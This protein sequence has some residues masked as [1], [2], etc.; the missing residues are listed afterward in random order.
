MRRYVFYMEVNLKILM[1]GLV[2]FLTGC[3]SDSEVETTGKSLI[4]STVDINGDDYPV[5][6]VTWSYQSKPDVWFNLECDK[7]VCDTWVL[8]EDTE[9]TVIISGYHSVPFEND[10]YCSETFS[11]RNS[12][13]ID[14]SQELTLEII[15]SQAICQ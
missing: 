10:E 13:N 1:L 2:L 9:G 15:Y 5:S 11:G 8:P 4:I 3:D 14:T 6:E 7:D 12:F